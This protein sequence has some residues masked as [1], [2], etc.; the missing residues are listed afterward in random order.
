MHSHTTLLLAL[1]LSAAATTATAAKGELIDLT[2]SSDGSSSREV[3]VLPGRFVEA[4]GKLPAKAQVAW[5]FEAGAALDF[6]VH[7]HEGKDVRFPARQDAVAKAS[8]V[9]DA[10]VAQDYCWMWTNPSTADVMLSY[11]L[12]RR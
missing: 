3:R 12:Q 2:W 11:T 10:P 7:Y 6:N 8:G 5:R 4:C 9:L 1:A